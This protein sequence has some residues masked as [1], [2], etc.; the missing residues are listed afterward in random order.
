MDSVLYFHEA[1]QGYDALHLFHGVVE[2]GL[3]VYSFCLGTEN[4]VK[5]S[6]FQ[7]IIDCTQ[8]K[9]GSVEHG[10]YLPVSLSVP[11]HTDE[12][13]ASKLRLLVVVLHDLSVVGQAVGTLLLVILPSRLKDHSVLISGEVPVY[14]RLGALPDFDGQLVLLLW[15]LFHAFVDLGRV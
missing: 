2:V 4:V 11:R 8:V 14:E 3:R 15:E 9:F 7:H 12:A 5:Y 1:W 10:D 13:G 6:R